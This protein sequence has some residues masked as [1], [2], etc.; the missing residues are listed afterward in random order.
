ME[1]TDVYGSRLGLTSHQETKRQAK[2]DLATHGSII[3]D[4]IDASLFGS[5]LSSKPFT[6]P[7]RG[8]AWAPLFLLGGFSSHFLSAFYDCQGCSYMHRLPDADRS[9]L[10]PQSS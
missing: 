10:P 9:Q 1:N 5:C 3:Q 7:V 4:G 6:D 8:F 2:E